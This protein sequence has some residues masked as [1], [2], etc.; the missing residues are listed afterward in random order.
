[1]KV[2]KINL[3]SLP[4]CPTVILSVTCHQIPWLAG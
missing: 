2:Q 3:P 1:L 4:F